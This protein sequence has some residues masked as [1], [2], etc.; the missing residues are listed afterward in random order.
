MAD[1]PVAASQSDVYNGRAG[2]M[3]ARAGVNRQLA[4]HQKLINL[5]EDE[6]SSE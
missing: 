2:E 4:T 5:F 6:P 3:I 1:Q